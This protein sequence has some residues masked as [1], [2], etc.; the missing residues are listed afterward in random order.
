MQCSA[1]PAEGTAHKLGALHWSSVIGQVIL[2]HDT[3]QPMLQVS[4]HRY[5]S[6]EPAPASPTGSTVTI[7]STNQTVVGDPD[8]GTLVSNQT[9]AGQ[10]INSTTQVPCSTIKPPLHQSRILRLPRF[11]LLSHITVRAFVSSHFIVRVALHPT[12]SVS[13]A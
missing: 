7:V 5:D 10:V 9:S 1:G 13:L 6:E 12:T 11:I 2:I 3:S 4:S 8:N